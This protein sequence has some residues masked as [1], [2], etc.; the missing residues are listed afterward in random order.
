MTARH[1]AAYLSDPFMDPGRSLWAKK[2]LGREPY[3]LGYGIIMVINI[4]HRI[5]I[6]IYTYMYIPRPPHVPLLKA[7]WSPLDGIWGVLKGN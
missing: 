3:L 7:L 6:Y 2:L 1:L 5:Y 4:I